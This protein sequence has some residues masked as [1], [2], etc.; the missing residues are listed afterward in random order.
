[1]GV[2]LISILHPAQSII[3]M[4]RGDSHNVTVTRRI[5]IPRRLTVTQSVPDVKAHPI[6][7]R[8]S[9][10]RCHRTSLSAA[11]A[12]LLLPVADP[13]PTFS[14]PFPF[15]PMFPVAIRP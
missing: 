3:H 6:T 9:F 5:A 10:S 13:S 4:T 7:R 2:L 14:P 1:M 12:L 11:S 15:L 8:P